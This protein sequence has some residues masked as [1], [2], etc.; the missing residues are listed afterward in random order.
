MHKLD[1]DKLD[2]LQSKKGKKAYY[3]RRFL[4]NKYKESINRIHESSR[5]YRDLKKLIS[6]IQESNDDRN[7]MFKRIQLLN[8]SVKKRKKE[9]DLERR[10]IKEALD[11]LDQTLKG[12]K[13]E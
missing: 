5:F 13:D 12:E 11:K 9:L 1:L 7:A 6:F 10:E 4:H 8:L 3:T 2:R